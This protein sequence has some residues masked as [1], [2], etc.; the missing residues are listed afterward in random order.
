VGIRGE[1][2]ADAQTVGARL[3]LPDA[4]LRPF[5]LLCLLQMIQEFG[6]ADSR[7]HG[8][9]PVLLVERD[10]AV[11]PARVEQDGVRSELLPAHR[12]AAPGDADCVAFPASLGHDLLH[13]LHR[14]GRSDSSHPRFV[15]PRMHVV[16]DLPSSRRLLLRQRRTG[17]DQEE[18]NESQF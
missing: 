9:E 14:N 17:E 5:S 1:R 18:R 6:P 13:L 4:P 10:D 16:D 2:P 11:Q 7:L 12:V 3:L 8:E 15:Q